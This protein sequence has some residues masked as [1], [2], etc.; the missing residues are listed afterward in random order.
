[1]GNGYAHHILLNWIRTECKAVTASGEMVVAPTKLIGSIFISV[2][3][4]ENE[5]YTIGPIEALC[6]LYGHH[7]PLFFV[8]VVKSKPS[9]WLLIDSLP[10]C[11][12][13]FHNLQALTE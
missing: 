2:K 9:D 11:V 3:Y 8:G 10:G 6:L 13:A 1:M 7:P 12:P 5:A 4:L